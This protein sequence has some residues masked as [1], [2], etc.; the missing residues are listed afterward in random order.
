MRPISA[1]VDAQ[2]SLYS[3]RAQIKTLTASTGRSQL[4]A[5]GAVDDFNHPNL[6]L[7]YNGKV[8]LGELGGILRA[9]ELRS[10]LR[11][12]AVWKPESERTVEGMTNRGWG[13]LG[14]VITSFEATGEPDANPEDFKEHLF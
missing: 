9:A 8:N 10:G 13:G 12:K 3:K 5:T 4:T 6:T 14:D 11:V 1:V 7:A 2:L